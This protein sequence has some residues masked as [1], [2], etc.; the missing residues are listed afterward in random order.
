MK[1]YQFDESKNPN[2][3]LVQAAGAAGKLANFPGLEN[4]GKSQRDD[5]DNIQPR[6]GGVFDVRGDGRDVVRGGWGIYT[7]VGY[8]NANVLFAAAD[9][10][11][12]GFGQ[13]F[14]VGP[15]NTGIV[16]SDGTFY[17]AGDPTSTIA[18]QNQVTAGAKNVFAIGWPDPRLEQPYQIQS[19]AGWSH[20]LTNDTV[21]SADYVNSLEHF[22]FSCSNPVAAMSDVVRA[23]IGREEP[24]G[25]GHQLADV[26][27]RAR[28]RGA[29]ERLQFGEGEFDGIEVGAVGR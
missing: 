7:D 29:E 12:E 10:S 11:P 9:A 27:E 26:V 25:R 22:R 16:K 28:T 1:G 17:H 8:T 3:A 19:N 5:F 23:L 24:E 21:I 15:V 4:F 13:V 20:Q 6:I 14:N 18:S 2:W